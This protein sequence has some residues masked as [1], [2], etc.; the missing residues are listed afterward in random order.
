M[1]W[2]LH[3]GGRGR[4]WLGRRLGGGPELG[5]RAWRRIAHASGAFVLVYYLLPVNAFVVLPTWGLIVV[6]LATVLVLEVLR[7]RAGLELPTIRPYEQGRVAS[8]VYWGVALAITVLFFPRAIAAAAIL[9]T[10]LVDP[11]AGELRLARAGRAAQ[12]GLPILAYG[13]LAFVALRW[14]GSWPLEGSAVAAFLAAIVGVIAER[15]RHRY[16]DDDLAM[17]LAPAI[18]L[19]LLATFVP[20]LAA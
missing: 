5:D 13:G 11:L 19:V 6:A 17:T 18:L 12:W 16:Y 4:A 9:G 10:A 8:Y 3:R 7:H 1:T 2:R 15:P 20:A 14:V